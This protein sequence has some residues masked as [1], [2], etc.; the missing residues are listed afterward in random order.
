M[1]ILYALNLYCNIQSNVLDLIHINVHLY[2]QVLAKQV[3]TM[4]I[5]LTR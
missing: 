2:I 4:L 3:D 5:K 1:V